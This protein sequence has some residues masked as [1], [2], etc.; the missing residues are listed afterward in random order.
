MPDR[1]GICPLEE[2]IKVIGGKWKVIILWRVL[3]GPQRFGELRRQMPGVTQ[4]TLTQQ[5]R[6]LEQHG[7]LTRTVFAEV[8][9]RVEYAATPLTTQARDLLR[10]MHDWARDHLPACKVIRGGADTEGHGV[11]GSY[12]T[13]V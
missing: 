3:A 7:F 6:E 13:D 1:D 8:P 10:A 5:L 2:L 12:S 11:R 4:K 9:P